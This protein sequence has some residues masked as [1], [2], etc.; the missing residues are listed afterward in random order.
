M[1]RDKALKILAENVETLRRDFAVAHL[2]IFGSVARDEANSESDIDILVEFMPDA[3][4]GLFEFSGLKLRLEE[5]MGIKVDLATV[6]ALKKQ[7]KERILREK[8]RA[9]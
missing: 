6:P 2:D 9:A 1:R 8:V 4:V 5:I 3:R 7:L